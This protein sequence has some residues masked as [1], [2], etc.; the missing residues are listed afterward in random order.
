MTQNHRD[1]FFS[2]KIKWAMVCQLHLKT[3][4]MMRWRGIHIEI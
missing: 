1:S 2:L 4:G 3:D